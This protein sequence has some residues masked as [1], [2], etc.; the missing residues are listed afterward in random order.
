ME[1]YELEKVMPGWKLVEKIGEGAYG[2]VY[3]IKNETDGFVKYS[4]LKVIEFPQSE[5]EVRELLNTGM[6][7]QSVRDYY[8]DIRKNLIGEIRVMESLKT[9]MNIVVIEDYKYVEHT[10]S[11]GWSIYIRMELLESLNEYLRKKQELSQKEVLKLGRDICQALECCEQNHII[12]RDI[13]PDNIFRNEYGN[14]KL[15]DFGIAKQMEMTKSVYS[16]KGTGMYMAPEVYRGEH[17]NK[18]VDIYSLGIMLYRLLNHGRFPFMP[19]YPKPIRPGDSEEAL[20]KRMNGERMSSPV[21]ADAKAAGIIA[22]AIAYHSSERYQSASELKE[23]LLKAEYDTHYE[24]ASFV[25]VSHIEKSELP[26]EERIIPLEIYENEETQKAWQ[27]EKTV[28]E[29]PKE[30]KSEVK[31]QSAAAQTKKEE[32]DEIAFHW[33]SPEEEQLEKAPE[34]EKSSEIFNEKRGKIIVA[35]FVI[36]CVCFMILLLKVAGVG[37][38]ESVSH[39]VVAG[40]EDGEVAEDA[41]DEVPRALSDT[42]EVYENTLESGKYIVGVHIPEGT[43]TLKGNEGSFTLKDRENQISIYEIL[44]DNAGIGTIE[45]IRCYAGA[46]LEIEAGDSEGM[47]NIYSENAQ[48]ASMTG[49]ANPLTEPVTVG[50]GAVAG[51]DFPAGTYDLVMEPET[52][53]DNIYFGYIVPGTVDESSYEDVYDA[54]DHITIWSS[55]KTVCRNLYLPEGTRLVME[56]IADTNDENAKAQSVNLVP[57]GTIAENYDGY[58]K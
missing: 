5:S 6:D 29:T 56:G 55:E 45:D 33:T 46:I 36:F 52:I 13:K 10:E 51:V 16:Q 7:Y 8:E 9:G 4:A 41:Y 50:D 3:K 2:K 11:V 18:T 25:K 14:Y 27:Q 15:G 49:T 26:Q 30:I 1:T 28:Q 38:S 19:N 21:R 43:Y 39:R 12:H 17:Y 58:Y 40:Y 32:P 57:S 37:D 34:I 44:D 20:R 53:S 47:I 24:P 42:G 23:E 31:E 35:V 54:T 48:T 22:K